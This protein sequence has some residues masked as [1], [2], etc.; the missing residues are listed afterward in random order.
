M[1]LCLHCRCCCL[2]LPQVLGDKRAV[3]VATLLDTKGPEIRTAMLKGG[4]DIELQ[5]GTPDV[6][7]EQ[8]GGQL[9]VRAVWTPVSSRL[10]LACSGR[11]TILLYRQKFVLC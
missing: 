9:P 7:S 11:N 1:A 3:H 2:L 10:Y 6:R 4:K 5:A 8:A